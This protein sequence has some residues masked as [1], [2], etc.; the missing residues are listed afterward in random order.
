VRGIGDDPAR[1]L[2]VATFARWALR[3]LV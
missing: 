2:D 1:S 3:G